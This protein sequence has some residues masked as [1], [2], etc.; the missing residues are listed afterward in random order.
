[1]KTIFSIALI[2]SLFVSVPSI[3]GHCGGI[4]VTMIKKIRL[5]NN[6]FIFVTYYS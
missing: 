2:Y 4:T 3:A 1:M 6:H 5:K